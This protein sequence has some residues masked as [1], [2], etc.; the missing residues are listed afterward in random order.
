VIDPSERRRAI[1][2]VF[3]DITERKRLERALARSEERF[4]KAF[5]AGPV[6]HTIS[7]LESGRI[8]EVNQAFADLLGYTREEAI[9]RTAFELGIFR[10]EQQGRRDELLERLNRDGTEPGPV[11][12]TCGTRTGGFRDLELH[13]QVIELEDK[14]CLLT[15]CV[16]VTERQ[17]AERRLQQARDELEQRVQERTG[18]IRRANDELRREIAQRRLAEAAVECQ[19]DI[20]LILAEA[21]A[22]ETGLR[23]CV[24]RLS[25]MG[26]IDAGG[27]YLVDD[28]GGVGLVAHTGISDDFVRSVLKY[29]PDSPNAAMVR[30]GKP[31]YFGLSEPLNGLLDD[32]VLRTAGILSLAVIPF[33][34]GGRVI[35]CF[36]VSSYTCSHISDTTR[37]LLETV[38]SQIGAAVSRLKAAEVERLLAAVVNQSIQG[39]SV[40]DRDGYFTYVNG[41]WA[42]MHGYRPEELIGMHFAEL[43]PPEDREIVLAT[44]AQVWETGGFRGE[45]RKMRS[46]GSHFP[47][48]K[49][50]SLVRDDHGTPTHVVAT[51]YDISR[52]KEAERAIRRAGEL[53][54]EAEKW[55][56]AA[57]LAARV[58]HE[59]NNPLA[60]IANSFQL[61][62]AA[63]P[64][65]HPHRR[66]A[67]II[68]REIDRIGR[69]VRRM[70]DLSRPPGDENRQADVAEAISDVVTMLAPTSHRHEVAIETDVEG[71]LPPARVSG[72]A[73]RQV[74]YNL[75]TNAVEA[76]KPRTSVHLKVWTAEN[77]LWITVSDHGRGIAEEI[78]SRIFEPFFTTKDKSS[79]EG[80]G[81]GLWILRTIVESAG[82]TIGFDSE[83]GRGTTFRISLP[84]A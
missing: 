61:V 80:L 4:S 10:E 71:R 30:E 1:F 39:V 37:Q 51:C 66:F 36:N 63:V 24:S 38:A 56:A 27:V 53:R 79:S 25:Q 72:D 6:A 62:K 42:E 60:G 5:Y 44:R 7:E 8:I 77:S 65:A 52:E 31:C 40:T 29:G 78:R 43:R 19:R 41:A 54:V 73:L 74:L 75:L 32:R 28:E 76:S 17:E 47:V 12:M 2:C 69:I 21:D 57:H 84:A 15:S 81:L 55:M 35:G 11:M 3:R 9:G 59:I 49:Q 23:A 83:V 33:H 34:H 67:E 45:M 20:A 68:E 50:I 64:E 14:R 13:L 22:I 46:D 18:Q 82:G 58:A 16:D 26:A 48:M 70:Y